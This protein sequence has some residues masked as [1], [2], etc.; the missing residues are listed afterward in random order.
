[1]ITNFDNW[2]KLNKMRNI[3]FDSGQFEANGKIYY[4]ENKLSVGRFCEFQILQRELWTGMTV[5]EFFKGFLDLEKL[6]NQMRFSDIAIFVNQVKTHML[7]VKE[8]EPVMFKIATLF[9]NT[10]DED[11]NKWDNDLVVKKLHDWKESGIDSQD[12]FH[13]ALTLAPGFV[14]QYNNIIQSTLGSLEVAKELLDNA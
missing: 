13:I 4:L 5:Q 6:L 3:D 7:K 8:K 11:R 12:F 1:M 2:N 14:E 9:V 10:E